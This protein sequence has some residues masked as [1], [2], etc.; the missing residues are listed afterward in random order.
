MYLKC[1]SAAHTHILPRNWPIMHTVICP[2]ALPFNTHIFSHLSVPNPCWAMLEREMAHLHT[3]EE[4]G[5][6]WEREAEAHHAIIKKVGRVPGEKGGTEKR[7]LE[8][9][10]G[11]LEEEALER[12]VYV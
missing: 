10:G 1:D 4:L 8:V 7:Q 3:P 6:G 5:V 9:K 2:L 11:F 12:K